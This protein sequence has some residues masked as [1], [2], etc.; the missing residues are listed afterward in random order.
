MKQHDVGNLDR[1]R[2][3]IRRL[4]CGQEDAAPYAVA[5]LG[6]EALDELLP[7]GGLRLGGLHEVA[8]AR[9][10]WDDGAATGFVLAL[11]GRLLAAR[12]GMLLWTSRTDDLYAPAAA[13]VLPSSRLLRVRAQRQ[14]DLLW[15]LEQGLRCGALAGVVGEVAGLEAVAARRLQLAAENGGRSCLLLQRCDRVGP[16]PGAGSPAVTRWQVSALPS[17]PA[18]PRSLVGRARWR[19]DLLRCRG[20]RPASLDVEWDDATGDLALAPALRDRETAAVA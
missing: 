3:C 16:R 4:E 12:A 9:A 2:E 10:E 14:E 7:G 1:L 15:T 17:D 13:A 18:L 8:P 11:A 20:G 19:L 5:S 6:L